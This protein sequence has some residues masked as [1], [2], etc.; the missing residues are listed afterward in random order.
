MIDL[1]AGRRGLDRL[2]RGVAIVGFSGLVAIGALTMLDA[3]LR[4]FGL[5][6]I[7]G[8]DDL[9]EVFFAVVIASCFPI[10]LLYNQNISIT[11]LGKVTGQRGRAVLDLFASIVTLAMFGF[12]AYE[13]IVLTLDLQLNQRVTS[14][15]KMPV[16]PWWWVTT[17]IFLCCIPV[18]LWIVMA[19]AA[20]IVS[21]VDLVGD[22]R[23]SDLDQTGI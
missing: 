15:I 19:R 18:Q 11:L 7:P 10:V 22:K 21:G 12:I 20:E 16:T 2:T 9:G 23:P 1:R 14:T 4:R 3:L 17:G 6:R 5:P 13:F 8:F